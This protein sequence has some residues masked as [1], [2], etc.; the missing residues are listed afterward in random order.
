[1][2][3]NSNLDSYN[4]NDNVIIIQD[5][6]KYGTGII[7]SDDNNIKYISIVNDGFNYQLNKSFI[8]KDIPST[9]EYSDKYRILIR[10]KSILG[11]GFYYDYDNN[12]LNIINIGDI[13]SETNFNNSFTNL[14]NL[15]SDIENM[16]YN[17]SEPILQIIEDNEDLLQILF[18]DEYINYLTILNDDN[19][20]INNLINFINTNNIYINDMILD[21]TKLLFNL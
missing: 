11:N 14:N 17:D 4:I 1:M 12:K 8:L 15:I 2:D 16:Y 20:N 13:T 18:L 7:L 6:G 5:L 10:R 9:L 3:Q 21:I 19:F